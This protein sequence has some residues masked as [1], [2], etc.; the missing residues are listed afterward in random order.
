MYNVII[1]CDKKMGENVNDYCTGDKIT[2]Y[3]Y[4]GILCRCKNKKSRCTATKSLG[5]IVKIYKN[6]MQ[7]MFNTLYIVCKRKR[8]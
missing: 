5:I 8:K 2:E 6:K 7:N 4:N 3:S 1:F